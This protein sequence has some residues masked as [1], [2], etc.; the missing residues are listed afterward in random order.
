[1]NTKR[2][3]GPS[4]RSPVGSTRDLT[5]LYRPRRFGDVLGQSHVT[6]PLQRM[7]A[8]GTVPPTLLFSGPPGTGKTSVARL[9]AA[10]FACSK[11]HGG[12]PCGSCPPCLAVA[13]GRPPLSVWEINAATAGGIDS[14]RSIQEGLEYAY[15]WHSVFIWD[16]AH[17]ISREAADA[18]LKTLEEP[19]DTTFILVT[20]EPTRLP[21][22]I[23]SRAMLFRFEPVPLGEIVAHLGAGAA[24]S[25]DLARALNALDEL[26]SLAEPPEISTALTDLIL[27]TQTYSAT[28]GGSRSLEALRQLPRALSTAISAEVAR[29]S[30][31]EV[32]KV[33]RRSGNFCFGS[34]PPAIRS[35][36]M[37]RVLAPSLRRT[38]C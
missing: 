17:R 34:G 25:G 6:Q 22:T 27:E 24:I 31:R 20:T 36:R 19:P 14:V 37:A 12:D 30:V 7:L 23:V 38:A 21:E 5:S 2:S 8:Q 13:A 4:T 18:L 16:E 32:K 15:H 11:P 3:L 29:W 9:V 35:M 26:Q 28:R 10:S 1:M 33:R